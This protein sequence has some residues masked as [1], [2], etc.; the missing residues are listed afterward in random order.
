MLEV[1]SDMCGPRVLPII[2][3]YL[4]REL[5]RWAHKAERLFTKRKHR[6]R[7]AEVQHSRGKSERQV[8]DVR[9]C[10]R[11]ESELRPPPLE[12][13]YTLTIKW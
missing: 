4:T 6:F 9:S 7:R 5:A 2:L 11:A 3:S 1:C 8:D 13:E 10:F 12:E